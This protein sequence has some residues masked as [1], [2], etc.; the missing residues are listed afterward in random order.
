MTLLARFDPSRAL[1]AYN[2][3]DRRGH[4]VRPSAALSGDA[5]LRAQILALVK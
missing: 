2:A 4:E 5:G 1:A 3:G